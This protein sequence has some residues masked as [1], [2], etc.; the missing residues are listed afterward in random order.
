MI[1]A[2]ANQKGGVGKTTTAI[3]LAA[4]LAQSG[5]RVLIIDMDAQANATHGLGVRLADGEPGVLEVLLGEK[6]VEDVIR[7]CTVSGLDVVP[8]SPDMAGAS[9]LLPDL[10]ERERRLKR[11][12]AEAEDTVSSYSFVFIDCPP[13]LGLLTVNSLVAA[14]RV[15]V[16]VQAE[17]Y[18]LEGLTQLMST[19]TA[20]RER[21]NP[22]LRIAGLVLTMVDPRTTLARQVEEEV[23][24]HFP[25]LSFKTVVPRNVRLAEAPSHGLPVSMLDPRCA[26][27][28]AYFDLAMEVAE[29]G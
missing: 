2:I 5:E 12:L 14:D 19:I 21:L 24:R 17:Y 13:S 15:I 8:S 29:Y 20:V 23:R 10:D 1:Y 18:A 27:S 3:N 26:G 16:P 6:G 28:D 11:A 7:T 22:S 9:V 25:S 4:S